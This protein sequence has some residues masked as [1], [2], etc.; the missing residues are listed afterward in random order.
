MLDETLCGEGLLFERD[1]IALLTKL[2]ER[3][4]TIILAAPNPVELH[5]V[6]A[7]IIKIVEGRVVVTRPLFEL[8]ARPPRLVA[9]QR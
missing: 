6:A 9:E 1:I 8:P 4:I 7:R 5:R 3:G 2:S